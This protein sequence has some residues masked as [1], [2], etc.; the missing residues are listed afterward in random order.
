MTPT[1][2]TTDHPP[3]A[4]AKEWIA[5]AVLSLP[6]MLVMMDLTVLHLAVPH[7]SAELA[8]TSSQLLWITDI[9]GFLIAGFLI[10]M[11]SLGDRIGR[12]R[13]LLAGAA[14]FGVASVLAAYATSAEMLIAARALMGI[15]GATLMPSTLSLIRNMF[16][17]DRQRTTAISLWMMSFMVGGS[18]G[19]LVGGALLE[20]FWWGSVFLVGV[21]VMLL[22]LVVGPLLL[23]EYRDPRSGRLDLASALLLLAAVLPVI[24]GIKKLASDG[25]GW[26]LIASV[27][28]GAVFAVLFVR[29]QRSLDDPLIDMELFRNR[30]FGATLGIMTAATFAMMGLNLFVMQYL[31]LVHGLSP[32]RAGLWVLPMTGAMMVGMVLVPVLVTRI[33]P[34]YLI[35]AGMAVSAAGIAVITQVG[36][37][38][39][40]DLL[41]TGTCIMAVGFT[42]AAALGTDLVISA[43]PPERAGA[44]SAVSETSNEFGGALGLAIL[45]SVGTAVYRAAMDTDL[46]TQLAP[47]AAGVAR[48]TLAGAVAVAGEL[49]AGAGATLIQLARAAFTDGLQATAA[50]SAIIAL[51]GA[52][53]A[54]VLLRRVRAGED[55]EPNSD[56]TAAGQVT[57][58]V[59]AT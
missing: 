8:P 43:A 50:V 33:R 38:G 41:I 45:G 36:G 44:A 32:F 10:T 19:P 24:Y 20:V 47:E 11:G 5:L 25:F 40:F 42:P 59:V 30:A 39:G 55:V 6:A 29:R 49:P 2:T 57:P 1:E 34:G 7:L 15:A 12:R 27:V 18:V 14:A 16:H 46:P 23:P 13:L 35:A 48:D 17:D 26:L 52:V 54:A 22:L 53:L 51:A 9:Y 31:Q 58:N 56:D 4:G 21:P 3:R 37:S 28:I